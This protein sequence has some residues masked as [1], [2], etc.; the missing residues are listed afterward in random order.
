MEDFPFIVT[1][2]CPSQHIRV[3]SSSIDKGTEFHRNG[4]DCSKRPVAEVDMGWKLPCH[5]SVIQRNDQSEQTLIFLQRHFNLAST[6]FRM[7]LI[8]M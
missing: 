6:T 8:K 2:L 1:S 3:C 7:S 4:V 5:G